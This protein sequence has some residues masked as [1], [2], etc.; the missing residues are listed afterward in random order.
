MNTKGD[1]FTEDDVLHA[2]EAY[3]DSYITYPIDT[4][5]V[6]TGIP[7]EKNK[8]NGRKQADHV[9]LMNFIRDEINGNKNWREGNGRPS[10]QDIVEEW[11]CQNQMALKSS[12][13]IKRGYR[14][15][16]FV[17]GGWI[18]A[19]YFLCMGKVMKLLD[20]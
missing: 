13:K 12:V 5:V 4:I 7:I 15:Q 2:L 11:Q 19:K 16:Q 9:K 18:I 8:R 17:N 14:I 1:A 3:T 6:R 20:M 10:K